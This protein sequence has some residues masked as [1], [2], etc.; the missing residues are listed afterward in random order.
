LV[1]VADSA[2]ESFYGAT[3]ARRAVTL[4]VIVFAAATYELNMTNAA[5]I[6][7]QMQGSFSATKDQISWVVTAFIVGMIMG[8]AW[9][10]WCADRFGARQ[11]F[12]FS[13]VAY[14]GTSLF[15]GL[16]GSLQ[17]EVLWRFAPGALGAPMMP[18]SQAIVLD[19]FPRRQHGTANAIWSIGIMVGPVFG[20][21][22]GGFIAE[23]HDWRWVFYVNLPLGLATFVGCWLLLPRTA[24]DPGRWFD[25]FGCGTLLTAVGASQ[26]MINRGGR[27]DWFEST[28]IIVEAAI[29]ALALY[30]FVVHVMT[31]PRPFV[32]TA[33]FRDR[34]VVIS[35]VMALIWGFLLHG[36][37]V[38]LALLMQELRG[39]P[40]L[41]L[42]LILAP[43]GFGVMVGAVIA[44][45]LVKYFDPR[46]IIL[47]AVGFL[48]L[49]SWAMSEW[50]LDVTAWDVGW[51][52]W[53][54]GFGTG[55]GFVTLSVKAYSTLDRRYR[56]EAITF[57]N[58]ITFMGIGAGIAFAVADVTRTTSV[59]R[60]TLVENISPYNKLL[61]YF[62]MP[63][64]WDP[65]S[66]A[67]L[68]NLDAE[69]MRQA[70]MVAYLEYF[71]LIT[72]I[73]V[74]TAPIVVLFSKGRVRAEGE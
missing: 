59:M 14:A 29:A 2:A 53:V 35:L 45:R 40:V 19:S 70:A 71:W 5:V 32:R 31:S 13:L 54:Q 44:S 41:T 17:E 11:F 73:A 65:A 57:H 47:V 21:V 10:G 36:V 61:R 43:R 20:P 74:F 15:C 64:A 1:A 8:F 37:L 33:I 62:F 46:Y 26:L 34:N 24:S 50:T 67:G 28:E 55:L 49:S 30:L 6:L 23:Y 48:V 22:V 58:L 12:L 63:D 4:G 60:A 66:L 68:A 25:W 39:Y 38:L 42:G 52:G 7:P 3:G 69:I 18:I 56:P 16:A 27:L 9:S 72:M 51:T